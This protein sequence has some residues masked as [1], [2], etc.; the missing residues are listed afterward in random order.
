[1]FCVTGDFTHFYLF[2]SFIQLRGSPIFGGAFSIFFSVHDCVTGC[3]RIW[4][5][6][7]L[8]LNRKL[9]LGIVI[10]FLLFGGVDVCFVLLFEIWELCEG[11]VRVIGF[12]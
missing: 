6:L 4:F 5:L 7:C 12:N 1:M 2:S 3:D 8:V 11:I 10:F 9:Y